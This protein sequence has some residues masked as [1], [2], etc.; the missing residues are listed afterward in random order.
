MHGNPAPVL[1]SQTRGTNRKIK[2]PHCKRNFRL[3]CGFLR[4][5]LK[6]CKLKLR[7]DGADEGA[8][9]GAGVLLLVV[10]LPV[11]GGEVVAFHQNGT[12]GVMPTSQPTYRMSGRIF[13]AFLH[14]AIA[15]SKYGTRKFMNGVQVSGV[16][17][18]IHAGFIGHSGGGG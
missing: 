1:Q 3:Q 12:G 14:S 15:S 5:I 17:V 9:A 10:D 4:M 18:E 6:L 11:V 16:H 8:E 2:D 7:D 13:A